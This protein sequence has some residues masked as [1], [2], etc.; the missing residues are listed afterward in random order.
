MRAVEL[1]APG[2]IRV[3]DDAPVP[4][5]GPHEVR[6]RVKAAGICGTDVHI[7][8]G[9]PSLNSLLRFPVT[10][11]HEFCGHIDVVGSE[12]KDLAPGDFVSAEMHEVCG[13]CPACQDRKY[14][15]CQNTKIRGLS[16]DGAFADYVV[17]SGKNI[18]RLPDS[19]PAKS[20]TTRM[21]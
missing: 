8:K 21:W 13:E 11:G 1:T 9:D 20:L 17:V 16:L 6:V 14:H 2:K 3:R 7:W 4:T 5:P 10:L 12:I 19:L 15:A 18:V